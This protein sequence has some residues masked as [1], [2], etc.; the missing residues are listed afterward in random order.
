MEHAVIVYLKLD[1]NGFGSSGKRNAIVE[2]EHDLT[3]AIKKAD[4]GEFAGNDFGQNL[5]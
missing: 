5:G 3:D 1:D 4:V 2:L